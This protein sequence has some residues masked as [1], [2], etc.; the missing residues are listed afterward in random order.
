MSL[1]T[2]PIQ[3]LIEDILATN[4]VPP[5]IM[6][7]LL[8]KKYKEDEDLCLHMAFKNGN[9]CDCMEHQDITDF[10][11]EYYNKTFKKYE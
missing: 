1:N 9:D 4:D 8:D 3:L 2:T 11:E 7:V 6:K 10:S 5:K